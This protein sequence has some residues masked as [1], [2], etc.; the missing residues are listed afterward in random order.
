MERWYKNRLFKRNVLCIKTKFNKYGVGSK[1]KVGMRE[2]GRL[3]RNHDKQK[4]IFRQS[5][6][7]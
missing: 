1:L 2:R 4:K 6:K 5:S 3:I 7:S